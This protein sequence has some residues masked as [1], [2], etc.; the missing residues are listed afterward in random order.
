MRQESMQKVRDSLCIFLNYLLVLAAV[1]TISDLFQVGNPNLFLWLVLIVIPFGFFYISKKTPQLIPSPIFIILLAV[2]SMAEKIMTTYDWGAYYYVIAFV[3]LIG[4]FLFYFVKKFLD[5][6]KLNENTASKIPIAD[7]F[8]NGMG[9][10]TFFTAC[11]SIILLAVVNV[12]WVKAIADRIWSG[13]LMILSFIFSDIKTEPPV[14]GK[15]PL[16]QNDPQLGGA[17]MSESISQET[18]DGIRNLMIVLLCIA[19]VIGFI[20]FLYYVYY[21]IKGLEG[22]KRGQNKKGKLLEN[23]DV[24][25]HCGIEKKSQRKAGSFLF[26]N[27]R[28][29]IRK[30]YQKNM[31]KHKNELIGEQEQSLLRYLTAKECCDKLS[32]QQLKLAYEKARYSEEEITAD[33][34]KSAK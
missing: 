12:D 34:V 3:Y 18:L 6:L 23:D 4:F 28:E 30:L 14:D 8:K 16:T 20:L 24:R 21:V 9:L 22:A 32:K 17:N 5:F 2:M 1:I 31:I 27:N 29:K 15:E 26:R 11:S 19:L 7:I 13:I 33:D 10:T 25:E